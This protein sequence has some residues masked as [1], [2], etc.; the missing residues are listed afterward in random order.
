MA[1]APRH[2]RIFLASPGDVAAER[3]IATYAGALDP[4]IAAELEANPSLV[5]TSTEPSRFTDIDLAAHTVTFVM[6]PESYAD[7]LRFT[8]APDPT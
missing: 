5:G 7:R 1:S 2:V 6:K 4:E 8:A 3:E